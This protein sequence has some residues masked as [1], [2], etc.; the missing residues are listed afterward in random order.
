MLRGALLLMLA[1]GLS[2]CTT[3]QPSPDGAPPPSGAPAARPAGR[4]A[5][6]PAAKPAVRADRPAEVAEEVAPGA[7]EGQALRLDEGLA[8]HERGT[9]SWYGLQFHGR[10]TASGERFDMNG[11]TAAHRTLPFGTLVRVRSLV[12]G[13]EVEVRIN[14]RGPHVAGRIIDLSR[15][16]AE[17]LGMLGMGMKSVT[18]SVVGQAPESQGQ[19]LQAPRPASRAKAPRRKRATGGPRR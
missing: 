16:A 1:W 19:A 5:A 15:A 14:D 10:R 3:L 12:N 2:A 11:F 6:T 13:R 4:P 18:L 8:E 9:A 17:A 7:T